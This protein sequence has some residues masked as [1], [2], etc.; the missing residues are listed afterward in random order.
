M[1]VTLIWTVVALILIGVYLSWTAGRLDRLHSRI[2]AARAALD[3]QLLR[4]R[5]SV[6]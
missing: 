4:D 6:V 2:D 3:A 1:T 5:K